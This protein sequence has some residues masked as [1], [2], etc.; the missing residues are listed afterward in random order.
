MPDVEI[1]K[2]VELSREE[3][4]ELLQYKSYVGR[5]GFILDGRPMVLPVNYLAA[6]DHIVFCTAPGMKLDIATHREVVAFEVDDNRPASHSGWSVL[7]HG[8]ASEI[9]DADEVER[10]R[11]GPLKTWTMLHNHQHWVRISIDDIS[12]RRIPGA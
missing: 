3:C 6:P 5:I 9:T 12:G 4:L 7:V 2:L 11:R 8:A 10:L 1:G